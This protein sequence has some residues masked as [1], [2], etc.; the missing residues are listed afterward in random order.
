MG[1]QSV[2]GCKVKNQ[3]WKLV[4]LQRVVGCK[5]RSVCRLRFKGD[6]IGFVLRDNSR[7]G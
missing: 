6:L 7:Q 5:R 4:K 1:L 2:V 3:T